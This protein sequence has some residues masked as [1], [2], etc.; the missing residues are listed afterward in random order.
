MPEH[1]I[2]LPLVYC[3]LESVG[4]IVNVMATGGKGGVTLLNC[5]C[6]GPSVRNQKN[7]T[8]KATYR[9]LETLF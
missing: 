7:F 8:N 3:T 6:A 9:L 5:D 4:F 1:P 2:Y